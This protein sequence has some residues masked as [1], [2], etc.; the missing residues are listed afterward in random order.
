MKLP[1]IVNKLVGPKP[2]ES[3]LEQAE[4]VVREYE[5]RDLHLVELWKRSAP[6]V[7]RPAVPA[8]EARK[9]A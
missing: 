4:R 5:A 6:I 8:S 7:A 2:S 1:W 9:A 3:A